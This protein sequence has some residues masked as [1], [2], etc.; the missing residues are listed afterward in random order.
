MKPLSLRTEFKR[1]II[2]EHVH[3]NVIKSDKHI[4]VR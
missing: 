4:G 1:P 3:Q 2:K